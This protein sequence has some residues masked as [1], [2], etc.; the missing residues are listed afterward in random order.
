[1]MRR[2]LNDI[3]GAKA[4]ALTAV[5][6]I[7]LLGAGVSVSAY[8]ASM[9]GLNTSTL[10]SATAS[11][12][13]PGVTM[14]QTYLWR[15]GTTYEVGTLTVSNVPTEC[16]GL[17][18]A[19]VFTQADATGATAATRRNGTLDNDSETVIALTTGQRPKLADV[20]NTTGSLKAN[21]LIGES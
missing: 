21:L 9:G 15:T 8:A 4:I 14:S 7:I 12:R 2:T 10:G 5:C 16:R 6:G 18:Y 17:P 11:T 3:R 20:N 19:L 13:C 1:M